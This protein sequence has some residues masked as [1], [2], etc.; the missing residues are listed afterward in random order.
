MLMK[1]YVAAYLLLLSSVAQSSTVFY[2]LA[3]NAPPFLEQLENQS[4]EKQ[5]ISAVNSFW[6]ALDGIECLYVFF[7]KSHA[8][9]D[10]FILKTVTALNLFFP[11]V[12]R[13]VAMLS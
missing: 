13:F 8:L 9:C 5:C 1:P 3:T 12:S 2:F 6:Q 4:F 11:A 7:L 10:Y